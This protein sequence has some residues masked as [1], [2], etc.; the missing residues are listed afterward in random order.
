MLQK[1]RELICLGAKLNHFPKTDKEYERISALISS[2]S[3]RKTDIHINTLKNL[4][5]HWGKGTNKLSEQTKEAISDFLGFDD[6]DDLIN[7]I[8]EIYNSSIQYNFLIR[9]RNVSQLGGCD[10][11]TRIMSLDKGSEII[12][13]YSPD[14]EIKVKVMGNERYK[15]ISSVNSSLIENDEITIK[16]FQIGLEFAAFDVKRYGVI[17]GD[18]IAASGHVITKVII[19]LE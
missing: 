2:K 13:R 18:Y 8:D 10:I 6:W 16:S 17:K 7:N 9:K 14:R 3:N 4:F 5:D 19:C 11:D 12:I 1:I 15:V